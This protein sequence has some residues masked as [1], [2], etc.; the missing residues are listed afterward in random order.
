MANF[1]PDQF[2]DGEDGLPRNAPNDI[3][4]VFDA[5]MESA[6][7]KKYEG[8]YSIY[9]SRNGDEWGVGDNMDRV[10][11]IIRKVLPDG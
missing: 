10:G 1:G 3:R 4:V 6:A 5:M 2:G 9:W 8:P 11:H 7:S